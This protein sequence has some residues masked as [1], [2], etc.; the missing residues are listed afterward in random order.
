MSYSQIVGVVGAAI[1]YW[2]GGPQGAQYGYLIGSGIGALAQPKQEIDGPRIQDLRLTGSEYGSPIPW[3]QGHP[4]ISGGVWW[5]SQKREIATTEEQGKGGG[6]EVTTYTYEVDVLIGLTD[7]PIVGIRRIWS[8][9]KLVYS[10]ADDAETETLLASQQSA[11]WRA[12]TVLTGA[13]DQLPHPVYEADVGTANACA[14]RGRGAVMIEGLQLGGSGIMPNLTFEVVVDGTGADEALSLVGSSMSNDDP[15]L[16]P[17]HEPGD[18]VVLIVRAAGSSDLPPAALDPSFDVVLEATQNEDFGYAASVQVAMDA[19]G[20][21]TEVE[22]ASSV[23]VVSLV[24]RGAIGIGAKAPLKTGSAESPV[25]FPALDL[26]ALDDSSYVVAAA[27]INQERTIITPSGMTLLHEN[28]TPVSFGGGEFSVYGVPNAEGFNGPTAGFSGGAAYWHSLAFEVLSAGARVSIENT[29][30]RTVVERLCGTIGL[31]SAEFDASALSAIT[32]PVRGLAVGQV[33]AARRTLEVLQ[34]AYFFESSLSDKLRFRPRAV[35]AVAEVAYEDLAAGNDGPSGEPLALVV[36]SDVEMPSQFAVSY[37]NKT[38]D[39]QTATERSDRIL[40]SQDSVS[41]VA[42][43]LGMLP[44]E[45][46]GVADAILVDTL[47]ASSTTSISVPLQY[48]ELEPGDVVNVHDGAGGQLRLRLVRRT[49]ALGVLAFEAVVDDASALTSAAITAEDYVEQTEI[50]LLADTVMVLLDAPLLRDADDTPGWYVAARGT[51]SNWPGATIRQSPDDVTY[52][53]AAEVA[54]SAVLGSC[55]STLGNWTGGH[56]FDELNALTVDVAHGQLSSATRS[57]LLEDRQLN[58]L[59][60]G[61]EV[62]QFRTATL[63][64][65]GIYVLTGLLRGRAGTEWAIGGHAAGEKCVLLRP[66]GLRRVA[67]QFSEVGQ[68]RHVKGV[69]R[70]KRED[71]AEAQTFTNTGVSGKPWAPVDLRKVLVDGVIEATWKRRTRLSTRFVGT[72]GAV[73]PLGEPTE[74]YQVEIYEP[75]GGPLLSTVTVTEPRIGAAGGDGGDGGSITSASV[76]KTYAKGIGFP[77]AYGGHVFGVD[78]E[79]IGSRKLVKMT[80][81]G[82]VVD[83]SFI[84]G[85]EVQDVVYVGSTCYAI[86]H[87]LAQNGGYQLTRI[88]KISLESL[89]TLTDYYEPATAGDAAGLA[90][91]GTHI[92]STGYIGGKLRKHAA[93]D[94]TLVTDY[95]IEALIWGIEYVG[96]GQFLVAVNSYAA[97][98]VI[99]YEPGGAPVVW[100]TALPTN[101]APTTLLLSGGLVFTGGGTSTF[102]LDADDGSILHTHAGGAPYYLPH[103]GTQGLTLFDG[104]VYYKTAAHLPFRRLHA[105]TGAAVDTGVVLPVTTLTGTVN[106]HLFGV[107]SPSSSF[108]DYDG[109]ELALGPGVDP[110][111]PGGALD[112]LRLVV[113]QIGANDVLGYPAEITL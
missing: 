13:D 105:T 12:L 64:E 98:K 21:I 71:T 55:L 30:L 75:N 41:V 66:R 52:S 90:W 99:K 88:Y 57:A 3:V 56:V 5:A 14:Y 51:N 94:L 87:F 46:K 6:A 49:D 7:N 15:V 50:R 70:G 89:S 69:T 44:D 45:A 92:W 74:R 103:T 60:V 83:S 26:E 54:E 82:L 19:D 24:F 11:P 72:T 18:M 65:P 20:S 101:S 31:T 67:T 63:T 112:G 28:Y 9:G 16:I 1:G 25:G 85:N 84:L 77:Y 33:S 58:A 79:G 109:Y 86:G 37:I 68:L 81:D 100:E 111:G 102:V 2:V 78:I 73:V 32:K 59:Q 91:D 95:T 8:N 42:M 108:L 29:S 76:V 47:A 36:A 34:A 17:E 96:S 113:R 27:F 53:T 4:R 104:Y 62:I 22:N 43:P 40:A 80:P 61:A 107:R 23:T 106:G 110:E 97:P 35:S 93:S 48:A 38:A 10:A 39:D